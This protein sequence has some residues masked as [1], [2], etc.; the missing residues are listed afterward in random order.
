M[1]R[2]STGTEEAF[3]AR[4][5]PKIE[6]HKTAQMRTVR[7]C[8]INHHALREWARRTVGGCSHFACTL[9][10]SKM[11]IP[12]LAFLLFQAA[13]AKHHGYPARRLELINESGGKVAVDWVNPV[14]GETV[15]IA[16]PTDNGQRMAFDSYVHH[17]F[18]VRLLEENNNTEVTTVVT[19]TEDEEDQVVVLKE[20]LHLER[21]DSSFLSTPTRSAVTKQEEDIL[22]GRVAR[23]S[24]SEETKKAAH[25]VIASCRSAAKAELS[26]GQNFDTVISSLMA[27]M[28][29][30]TSSV[31]EDMNA[32]LAFQNTLLKS[33]SALAE[34]YTCADP[35]MATS[36]PKEVRTW[37]H[38]GVVRE[39]GILH[40][41]PSSQIHILKNFISAE[42]CEAIRLAA[43]S[44]LHRGTVADGKGG[45]RLSESRKAWQAGVKAGK[46]K[47]DR[48]LAVKKRLFDYA[49]HATGY[50]MS[51]GMSLAG[52]EDIM[53][54]QYFGKGEDDPTP[55][56]YT[57]HCDGDCNGLPHKKGARVATMVM[58]CDV[59]ELGGA[60][61]FQTANV[62]V[63]PE[64]GAAAFFSYMD[65]V[66]GKHEDGFTTHSGCPVLSGTKR[67]AVQWM[68]VGV[69]YE[70]PWDSFD[71]NTI[72]KT[73]VYNE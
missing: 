48:I 53:S 15:P 65:P 30:R 19:V 58:Y 13:A 59:P 73:S 50:G 35:A 34:N 44:S 16:E 72:S 29:G 51:Y 28:E 40:D 11:F 27:C 64:V 8:I 68:R 26:V 66:T 39:V 57:P 23:G 45:S 2:Y 54:I 17:S 55:D 5:V 6:F 31:L 37:E 61:N 14:T 20:G 41:R 52:Q 21:L 18:L 62:Y 32:E 71:T 7:I 1:V 60:T 38:D 43:E 49:N 33:M 47:D 25:D 69:D 36:T 10:S 46:R 9:R 12:I 3:E 22:M 24:T 70:N 42:E 4:Q 67:I 56:R 63:K